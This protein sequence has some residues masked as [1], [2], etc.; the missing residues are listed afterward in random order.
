MIGIVETVSSGG[1]DGL[2]WDVCQ[3]VLKVI[4]VDGIWNDDMELEVDVLQVEIPEL[5]EMKVVEWATLEIQY[6][7][8]WMDP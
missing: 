2:R 7:E 4:C 5:E 8:E 6:A 1:Y 3:G